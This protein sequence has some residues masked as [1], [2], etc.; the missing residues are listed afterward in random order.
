MK[1]DVPKSEMVHA[2]ARRSLASHGLSWWK[3]LS[4]NSKVTHSSLK[5]FSLMIIE[6]N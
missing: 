5:I 3:N 4:I 2:G 1:I 6:L